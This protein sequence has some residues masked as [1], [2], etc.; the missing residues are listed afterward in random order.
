[1]PVLDAL[2]GNVSCGVVNHASLVLCLYQR[3]LCPGWQVPGLCMAGLLAPA[4]LG[5][6]P[7][8]CMAAL[9][10]AVTLATSILPLY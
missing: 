1:M 9:L 7:D 6:V 3:L 4:L 5:P 2:S 8:L 10:T